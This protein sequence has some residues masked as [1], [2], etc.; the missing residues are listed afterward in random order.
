M[1]F[2][3]EGSILIDPSE[4]SLRSAPASWKAHSST[5]PQSAVL[6]CSSGFPWLQRGWFSVVWCCGRPVFASQP[7]FKT[8]F[9]YF[10]HPLSLDV[11]ALRA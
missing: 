7:E 11:Q 4:L 5:V 2:M 1:E 6:H 3:L 9:W 10:P 8:I